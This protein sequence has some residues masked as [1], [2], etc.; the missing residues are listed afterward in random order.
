[1]KSTEEASGFRTTDALLSR[2]ISR[3]LVSMTDV[4][5]V[6]SRLWEI[7]RPAMLKLE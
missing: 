6:T 3:P 5:V 1:M 4:E 7:H 2:T